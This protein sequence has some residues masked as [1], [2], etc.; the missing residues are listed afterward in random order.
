VSAVARRVLQGRRTDEVAALV[1]WT[2]AAAGAIVRLQQFSTRR[3]LWADEAA[4]AVNIVQR[5]FG[6]LLDPLDG[7]QGAPVLFL[8]AQRAMV[9]VG[10]NNEYALRLV[11]LAAGIALLPLVYLTARRV[12]D[13]IVASVA[14]ALVAGSPALV[15]YSTEVKQ[16]SSDAAVAMGLVLLALWA[17]SAEQTR[18]RWVILG[19]AGAVAV[20]SAHPAVFV[21]AG[22]GTVLAVRAAR[23]RDRRQIAVLAAVGATWVCSIGAL[24]VVSLRRLEQNEFL[25]DFWQDGFPPRPLAI[26]STLRWMARTGV[27]AMD[28]P[29]GLALPAVAL[30]VSLIGLAILARR[31]RFGAALMVGFAPFLLVAAF[32]ER[33][34]VRGRLLLFVVPLVLIALAAVV[35]PG[36][37]RPAGVAAVLVLGGGGLIEVARVV[38]DPPEF[39]ES[40]PAFQH[41]G[42]QRLDGDDLW[43]HDVTVEP[44]RYYGPIVGV[45]AERRTRWSAGEACE[46]DASGR[47]WVVFAYTLSSR[48]DDEAA[49]LRDHLASLADLVDERRYRDAA[50]WLFD[51]DGAPDVAPRPDPDLGC[52]VTSPEPPVA[53]SGLSTGPFGTGATS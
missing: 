6:G 2:V 22:I 19:A 32:G 13:P 10:G 4:L 30:V 9:L 25:T 46:I 45:D 29:V 48:P 3:S 12:A 47:V 36:R 52:V 42:E 18:A 21:L 49:R 11:P 51:F 20:W 33:Y 35:V 39:A 7:N 17:A 1:A 27:E 14:T 38:A 24:Y 50:V 26:G 8:F 5:D 23:R 37:W 15:R 28:A 53:R 34:P 43:I 31:N 40:R 44:Y 16:Y 41:V